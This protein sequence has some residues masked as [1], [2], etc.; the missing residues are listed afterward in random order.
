MPHMI[1]QQFVRFTGVGAVGTAGHYITLLFLVE[2]LGINAVPASLA[3]F[4]VGALIN[5]SLNRCYTFRS[6]VAHTVAVPRFFTI[7]AVGAGLNTA[8]MSFLVVRLSFHY[9]VSQML[10]TGV[11]LIWGFVGNRLWTFN[12]AGKEYG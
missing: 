3:G 12:D 8:I 6:V 7:A 1:L 5:Y 9:F 10:A 2:A 4:V 11:V